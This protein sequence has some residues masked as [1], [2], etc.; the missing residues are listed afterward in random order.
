MVESCCT[1]FRRMSTFQNRALLPSPKLIFGYIPKVYRDFTKKNQ[2][3]S[4]AACAPTFVPD[5][6]RTSL[7]W[8]RSVTTPSGGTGSAEAKIVIGVTGL[9]QALQQ[10]KST[11]TGLPLDPG[12]IDGKATFFL[13]STHSQRASA[14]YDSSKTGSLSLTAATPLKNDAEKTRYLFQSL[15]I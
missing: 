10:I 11:V 7:S 2:I 8:V 6:T 1:A 3:P 4:P 12:T 13:H 14:K 5:R 9:S 15:F